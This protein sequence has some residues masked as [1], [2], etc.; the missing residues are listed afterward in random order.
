MSKFSLPF[1]YWP[2]V[3]KKKKI[4]KQE[5]IDK[6]KGPEIVCEVSS[7]MDGAVFTV[8]NEGTSSMMQ[9]ARISSRWMVWG[10]IALTARLT[11]DD[12]AEFLS[13]Q[14]WEAQKNGAKLRI[15]DEFGCITW[16]I[17]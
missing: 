13:E 2:L 6:L 7:V 5:F 4:K 11:N 9:I 1:S 3:S 16:K 14:Y 12:L 10:D 17:T 8:V 15:S